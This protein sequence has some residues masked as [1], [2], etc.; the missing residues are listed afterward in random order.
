MEVNPLEML[1]S[2][3]FIVV[4]DVEFVHHM[5]LGLLL[6]GDIRAFGRPVVVRATIKASMFTGAVH[7]VLGS[8]LG[9]VL[10]GRVTQSIC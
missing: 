9:V 4:A 1:L 6:I 3:L 5:Q 7:P 8:C 2:L 10:L